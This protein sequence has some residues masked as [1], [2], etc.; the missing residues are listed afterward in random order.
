MDF[1]TV[2]V[3][4][5]RYQCDVLIVLIEIN[6]N[7]SDLIVFDSY[8]LIVENY[9]MVVEKIQSKVRMK[10]PSTSGRFRVRALANIQNILFKVIE[11]TE[12]TLS[13]E[14]FFKT[15]IDL[16]LDFFFKNYAL[17]FHLG[18]PNFLDT[19]YAV[20]QTLQCRR[21]TITL[22][23]IAWIIIRSTINVTLSGLCPNLLQLSI[24]CNP[25]LHT[26]FIL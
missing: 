25:I 12:Q 5:V 17:R 20:T 10:I 19:L 21:L 23:V 2:S 24:C 26:H 9:Y 22:P 11:K 14:I 6:K 8:F 7:C 1:K 13:A 18:F 3:R 4:T 15:L 16:S